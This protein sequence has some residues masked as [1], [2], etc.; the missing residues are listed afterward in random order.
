MAKFRFELEKGGLKYTCPACGKIRFVRYLDTFTGDQVADEVGRCDREDSCGYHLT[1][2]E[3]FLLTGKNPLNSVSIPARKREPVK[4]QELS[5]LDAHV[6]RASL[7]RYNQ[8]NFCRWLCL[9]FG[10]QKAF[11][12]TAQYKVGTSKHRFTCKDFPG[13]RSE[14]GSSVFWQIDRSGRIR[15]GKVM[16]YNSSTGR[17][18]KEP[19]NHVQ[20]VH[21]LMKIEPYHLQQCLFG[22]Q[23]LVVDTVKPV[24]IVESEKTA[25]VAAGFMPEF[26]WTATAGKNNLNKEK[27]KGLQGRRVTL[28]PDLGAFEKWGSIADGM[29]G[30]KVSDILERR[31]TETDRVAGLDLADYLLREQ[32]AREVV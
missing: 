27:L 29:P 2:K 20:W 4:E 24:A 10:E 16:L 9:E 6:I 12:L 21:K 19:F 26:I 15:A 28:F 7:S 11:E 5:F 25:I 1:P 30:V 23:L 17:R 22:E 32:R 14:A 18:V 13:Y 8:N 31:A 3:H